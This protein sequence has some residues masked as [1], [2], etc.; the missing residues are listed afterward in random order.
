M[1]ATGFSSSGPSRSLVSIV[2]ELGGFS[3]NGQL[4]YLKNMSKGI[5]CCMVR[6]SLFESMQDSLDT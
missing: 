2:L 6:L 1:S 5:I 3:P 4:T